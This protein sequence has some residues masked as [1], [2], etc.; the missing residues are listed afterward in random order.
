MNDQEFSRLIEKYQKG[1]LTSKEKMLLDEWFDT[2]SNESG[3]A[4]WGKQEQVML[5][6]K[7]L[8]KIKANDRSATPVRTIYTG[9]WRAAAAIALLVSASYFIWQYNRETPANLPPMEASSSGDINKVLLADGTL[10]WLKGNSKLTYPPH[11][12]GATRQVSLEGEALFEV[13]KD[14]AHPFTIQCGDLITTVL[15]TSFNIK[16]V[17]R[18]IE[19]VVLTG[20]VS[21]TSTTDK[22]GIVVLPNEKAIYNGRQKQLAI[23]E[24]AASEKVA[25]VTGTAYSMDFEDTQIREVI[26]RIEGKFDV[27]VMTSDPKVGNCLITA[28]FTDQSLE[29]TLSMISQVHGFE[30]EIKDNTVLLKGKGCE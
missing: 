29:R 24:T 17:D 10:V 19:V 14:H 2:M 5:K 16:A 4:S 8:R 26:R 22:K 21:L 20:K 6:N 23:V 7:I 9:A 13:A 1:L 11:F 12:D 3:H 30:Y 28:D 18:N 27:K 15:G 25:A